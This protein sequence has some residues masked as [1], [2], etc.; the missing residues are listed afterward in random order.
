MLQQ[1]Y[2]TVFCHLDNSRESFP[3]KFFDRFTTSYIFKA[4]SWHPK[5]LFENSTFVGYTQLT[6]AP[7]NI[8]P[9]L[10]SENA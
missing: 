9:P 6:S 8:L 5:K 3:M 10:T 7:Q 1:P 2:F 4:R